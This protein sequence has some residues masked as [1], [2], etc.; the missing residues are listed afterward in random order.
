MLPEAS[1]AV[2]IGV[3]AEFW[4]QQEEV[5]TTWKLECELSTG[6]DTVK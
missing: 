6:N 4:E 5:I 2:V 1:K 3:E